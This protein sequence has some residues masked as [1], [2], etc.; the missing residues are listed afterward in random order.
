MLPPQTPKNLVAG[1]INAFYG[2][3]LPG[4]IIS[5]GWNRWRFNYH[6]RTK[7]QGKNGVSFDTLPD[8]HPGVLN[9]H[10]F[11]ATEPNRD[12]AL[13][14]NA[15]IHELGHGLSDRLT[16]GARTKMCMG[17]IESEGLSEGY[18]DMMA[19]I[20]TARSEDTRNTEK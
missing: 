2:W 7:Q 10:I 3:E 17:E 9:L 12:P 19:L 8:G 20:F 13:D 11:T 14:N 16:G 4:G 1:A 6:K 18:S 5:A 15:M